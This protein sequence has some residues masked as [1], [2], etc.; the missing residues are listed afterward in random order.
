MLEG[1]GVRWGLRQGHLRQVAWAMT[2]L[3]SPGSVAELQAG[4]RSGK[5]SLFPCRTK[6]LLWNMAKTGVRR[7]KPGLY[8]RKVGSP[9]NRQNGNR[10]WRWNNHFRHFYL[11]KTIC[12]SLTLATWKW[13]LFFERRIKKEAGIR[14]EKVRAVNSL[15]PEPVLCFTCLFRPKCPRILRMSRVIKKIWLFLLVLTIGL[16]ETLIQDICIKLTL[17]GRKTAFKWTPALR[18]WI[19]RNPSCNR[20]WKRS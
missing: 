9:K 7:T 3:W 2:T 12:Y 20:S 4:W 18:T 5:V 15:K 6:N 16:L 19:S 11:G 17:N 8:P 14:T 10:R 13:F 1:I